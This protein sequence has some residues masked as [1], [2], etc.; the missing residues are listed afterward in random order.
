MLLRTHHSLA[1]GVR[2]TQVM[3]SMCDTEGDP[4]VVGT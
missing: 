3:F 2:L 4:V 1:D